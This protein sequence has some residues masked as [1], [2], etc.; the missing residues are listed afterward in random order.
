MFFRGI[1]GAICWPGCLRWDYWR[2]LDI[3]IGNA[4]RPVWCSTKALIETANWW[5]W[6]KESG[7]VARKDIAGTG[8]EGVWWRVSAVVDCCTFKAVRSALLSWLQGIWGEEIDRGEAPT[9]WDCGKLCSQLSRGIYGK[10]E[11]VKSIT[12]QGSQLGS[13]FFARF[14][15]GWRA[16]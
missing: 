9:F 14:V 1:W 3:H 13:G 10:S 12:F 16:I 7:G 4:I 11:T 15:Y 2:G 5:K 8:N 6:L